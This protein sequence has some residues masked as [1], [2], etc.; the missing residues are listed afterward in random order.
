MSISKWKEVKFSNLKVIKKNNIT[1]YIDFTNEP[2]EEAKKLF[3]QQLDLSIR[4]TIKKDNINI[5]KKIG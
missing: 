3:N 2:S 4:E 5:D 1:F